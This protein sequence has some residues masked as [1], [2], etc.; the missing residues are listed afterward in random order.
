MMAEAQQTDA[1]EIPGGPAPRS[2]A[3]L[4]FA[5]RAG[6]GIAVIALLLWH[7]DAK[8]I[9]KTLARERPAFFI[10]AV[11]LYV[12]SQVMSAFR[13]QLLARVAGLGG[14][15]GEYLA[16]YFVGMFTNLF[17]PG[18]IGGDAARAVYLGRRH[19]R[20][21][22]AVAS[23]AADR[24]L[25]LLALFW[26]AAVCAVTVTTVPLPHAMVRTTVAV[27]IV[28]FAAFLA[29]PVISGILARLPMKIR[30]LAGPAIVYLD[31]PLA[32]TPAIVLSLLLQASLAIC[33]Y[34]L[35]R[36]L[37]LDLPLTA[38]LLC[39]PI[40]NVFASLPVT[41]NGLGIRETAYLVLFGY[42]GIAKPDAIA[43]GLLWFATTITGGVTGV[44]GL[45]AAPIRSQREVEQ[46][47]ASTAT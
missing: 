12:A 14:R 37:G 15:F 24:G 32:L 47:V 22:E 13:W 45:M 43:L 3:Y 8:P 7:F 5:I 21:G 33:Q 17:V 1:P 30:T 34:L 18:L 4:G 19:G 6:L 16:Y 40:A 35:A 36:G 26:M 23:V 38:F 28:S 46:P 9:L 29:G 25:G 31:R 42:A 39:V 44:F 10:A 27:G 41:F 11:V 2:R 20:I